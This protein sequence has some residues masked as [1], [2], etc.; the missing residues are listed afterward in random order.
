MEYCPLI[1]PHK[2]DSLGMLQLEMAMSKVNACLDFHRSFC[3]GR[4]LGA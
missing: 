2:A 4:G 3:N 1:F